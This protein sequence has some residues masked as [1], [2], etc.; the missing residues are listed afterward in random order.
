MKCVFCA[1]LRDLLGLSH[2]TSQQPQEVMPTLSLFYRQG[3]W[4]QKGLVTCPGFPGWST[5]WLGYKPRACALMGGIPHRQNRPSSCHAG[6]SCP[7]LDSLLPLLS[8][9]L[10]RGSLDLR[11]P[12]YL[13]IRKLYVWRQVA[14]SFL[15]SPWGVKSNKPSEGFFPPHTP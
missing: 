1:A 12:K 5:L 6:R 2:F 13:L 3:N 15:S 8:A 11:Q 10:T 7:H 9:G 14:P 4:R